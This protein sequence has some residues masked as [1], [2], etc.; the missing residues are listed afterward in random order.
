MAEI[1]KY[2]DLQTGLPQLVT[3]IKAADEKVLE[4]AKAYC[5]GK[6]SQFESAGAAATA[7][8]NA[9]AHADAEIAKV[10]AEVAKKATTEALEAE[11][12]RA[13]TEEG[14]LAGLIDGVTG[15]A[16]KN[17]EDIAAIN[18]EETGILKQAKDYT[19]TEVAKVQGAVDGVVEKL[20]EVPTDKTVKEY[21]DEKTAGIA[22]DAALAELQ[23]AV[24]AVEADVATIK[25]DY[26]KAT[27]KE[28]LQ[29]NIDTLSQAHATDKAAI[30]G[31]VKAIEDDYLKA[32]DKTE[33][34]GNIDG[35]SAVA[36]AA[37]KATDLEAEVTRA[38]GEEARI[39]GLVTSEAA[40]AAEAEGALDER[41]VE[42][43]AFFKLAEGEQLDTALDTL[44][45]IQDY[46]TGEGAV[47]D[48]MILDI[49]A[50]KKAIED[51]VA[52]DHDFAGADAALK[53]ELEGKI[54]AKADATVVEG[55][56]GR[57]GTLET[58]MDTVE[59][60]VATLEGKMTTVEGAVATKVEQEAYNTKIGELEGADADQVERI[61]ALEAKFED[62]DGS[63]ADMVADAKQEAIEVAAADATT[64][65]NTAEA[66]AK[67]YTDT[68]VGKDRTRLDALE[69]DTHTHANKAELDKFVDGDKAKLD[70]AVAKAH[71][72]ANKAELDKIA[73]GD[74]AKWNAAE[75]NAKDYA[76][77]L[78][79]TMTTKV[80]GV[81][82]KV[83]KNTEDIATKAAQ[84][85]LTALT[86]RVTTAE[87]TVAA[88]AAFIAGLQPITAAEIT[89][90][91]A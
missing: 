63:V 55:V 5:D 36:N 29:G 81:E 43:E 54:N 90:L 71:E 72:H 46:V 62:G 69:A 23:G 40:R 32:A 12:T 13:T 34:Q 27:D 64:K 18:N 39:E 30:E 22:T 53:S 20:G 26:L 65:A 10:N 37:A 78:N 17:A 84:A 19:D 25:G 8:A 4:A 80:D 38:K 28:E 51:H 86:E 16:D 61:E 68:E 57:V 74:V 59:G 50:N 11:V 52:T 35:V 1:K 48:Q 31:R 79:T 24:D 83:T 82:A 44:K 89:A 66:N 77:G 88:N 3:E 49:A 21:I 60:K 33:L 42:V 75:Q 76:D 15:K 56:A 47:A 45:E 91:F 85:D 70:D 87:S 9:K 67:A 6:D 7:E 2:L 58:E 14:R 73:E 41:L